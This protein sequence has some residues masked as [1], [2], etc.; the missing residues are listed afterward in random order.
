[1]SQHQGR[2][3]PI[4]AGRKKVKPSRTSFTNRHN[5]EVAR[6]FIQC[7]DVQATLANFYP[8]LNDHAKEQRSKLIYQWKSDVRVLDERCK[9]ASI[10]EMRTRQG[11]TTPD[12][13]NVAA[14]KFGMEVQQK[15]RDLGV[16]K[17]YS[18]D[19]T[20]EESQVGDSIGEHELRLIGD[21]I[22]DISSDDELNF[23]DD[24]DF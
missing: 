3:K 2:P 19:Q 9:T 24:E 7:E 23:S 8:S 16:N 1:M 10:A 21:F 4:G 14:I 18:A 5:L 15:M 6:H 11:R 17:V 13:A 12:K 22:S 20:A